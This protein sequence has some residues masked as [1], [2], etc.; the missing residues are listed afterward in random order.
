MLGP[1]A[2]SAG[3]GRGAR[4][5]LV[6]SL[7]ICLA[8]V[9]TNPWPYGDLDGRLGD[10]ARHVTMARLLVRHGAAIWTTPMGALL[11]ETPLADAPAPLTHLSYV[12]PP[13]AMAF[14]ALPAV[15]A[16]IGLPARHCAALAIATLALCAHL[17][18]ASALR[19]APRL[20]PIGVA[21]WLPLCWLEAC[22]WALAGQMD[23]VW[24][25]LGL[26]AVESAV[27]R[28]PWTALW[29]LA[30]AASSHLRAALLLPLGLHQLAVVVR[31]GDH[32]LVARRRT[33]VGIA[34]LVSVALVAL[35]GIAL[36]GTPLPNNNRAALV[37][38][39]V[40]S[41]TLQLGA[42]TCLA[43]LASLAAG[44]A[45]AAV[46]LALALVLALLTPQA[47]PWHALAW[48]PLPLLGLVPPWPSQSP[49]TSEHVPAERGFGAAA[50]SD[51]AAASWAAA[52][53]I[54]WI[55]GCYGPIYRS[56]PG[57]DWLVQAL[58]R[59]AG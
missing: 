27:D 51:A 13:F 10:A 24:L 4:L 54:A 14:A 36:Y 52:A 8:L 35:C 31:A 19:L 22:H 26:R 15:L 23:V 16:E 20:G 40:T 46:S 45:L 49:F 56:W 5:A 59:W 12:Y 53:A 6:A 39:G 48:V 58:S 47:Q 55:L 3:L 50:L 33:L 2:F 28:K 44:R 42:F 1:L 25:W 9:A 38:A 7:T 34:A 43:A 17:A 57:A 37:R 11:A 30:F 29:Y 32:R 41:W 21:L 18:L